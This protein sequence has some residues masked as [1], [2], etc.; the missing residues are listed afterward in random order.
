MKH[1]K[2][3]A[4]NLLCLLNLCLS[5]QNVYY[6]CMNAGKT[7][8]KGNHKNN[9]KF[10]GNDKRLTTEWSDK[11]Y[12]F[13]DLV[14]NGYL[15]N[16]DLDDVK[17]E[18]ADELANKIQNKLGKYL[19]E[20][21]NIKNIENINDADLN[22]L[23]SYVK[24][25]SEYVGLKAAELLDKNLEEALKPILSK[26][27]YD[28]F[29][30]TL[31]SINSGNLEDDEEHT[32]DKNHDENNGENHS[33]NNGEDHSEDLNQETEEFVDDL[34]DEYEVKQHEKLEQYEKD[35]KSHNTIN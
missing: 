22:D 28:N 7:A 25:I 27:S 18:L 5:F 31:H 6:R 32:N 19:K 13:M 15:K 3:S 21:Q 17:D 35:V 9:M 8:N 29:E 26:T 20:E 23:K 1:F 24:D 12:N 10:N 14:K 30:D 34:V 2:F 11:G 33:E 16:Q 4:I